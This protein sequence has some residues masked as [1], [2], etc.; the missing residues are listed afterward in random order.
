MTFQPTNSSATISVSIE[1]EAIIARLL[2]IGCPPPERSS[3][4]FL[5]AWGGWG[6][7]PHHVWHDYPSL[8]GALTPSSSFSYSLKMRTSI[9]MRNGTIKSQ[10]STLLA[11]TLTSCFLFLRENILILRRQHSTAFQEHP[12]TRKGSKSHKQTAA[13]KTLMFFL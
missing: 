3:A 5:C 12:P 13:T 8:P 1:K 6:N 2:G 4:P 11:H 10:V 7:G 9:P